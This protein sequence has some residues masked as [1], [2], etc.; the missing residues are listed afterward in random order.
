MTDEKSI[1]L[2]KFLAECGI[3]SRRKCEELITAGMVRVNGKLVT[4]LGTKVNPFK[5]EV[6]VRGT[7]VEVKRYT[8]AMMHKPNDTITTRTD[9]GDRKTVYGSL[10]QDLQYLHP[11]GR[12]DRDTTGLLVFTNDGDLTQALLHPSRKVSKVYR[13]MLNKPLLEADGQE[14]CDG[15]MLEGRMTEP[16]KL[17][18]LS[19]DMLGWEIS[20]TEGRNRQIRKMFELKG[21]EVVKLKRIRF[22]PLSLGRLQP[23]EFRLLTLTE[24]NRLRLW[25]N[26]K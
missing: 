6:K 1:R 10:P 9:P 20:I 17:R 7:H 5:D 19:E 4:E 12:L 13:L 16:C 21:Y 14:L 26:T 2:Q 3:D 24:V 15:I 25:K 22:G 8:Y 11:V 18:L 23:G